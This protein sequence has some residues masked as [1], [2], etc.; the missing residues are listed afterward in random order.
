MTVTVSDR[1]CIQAT[2]APG[3]SAVTGVS[4]DDTFWNLSVSVTDAI[5][6]S[7]TN[8]HAR[9]A[10]SPARRQLS[11]VLIPEVPMKIVWKTLLLLTCLAA[12]TQ[13]PAAIIG[14]MNEDI[15]IFLVNAS[16]PAERPERPDHVG[17][18]RELGTDD[19][20]RQV[21]LRPGKGSALPLSSTT[22]PWAPRA[23]RCSTSG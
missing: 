14:Q 13:A 1:R 20:H 23:K 15:D 10:H 11:S 8:G 3:Y 7:T 12:G 6:N 18:H 5:T 22:S 19:H 16:I 9:R 21:R 2:T 17:Q 4:P